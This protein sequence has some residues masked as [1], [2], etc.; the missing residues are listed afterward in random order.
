MVTFV[1]VFAHPD[2]DAYGIAGSVGLHAD[3]ADFSSRTRPSKRGII[4]QIQQQVLDLH[5]QRSPVATSGRSHEVD[6]SGLAAH[7][8]TDLPRRDRR[9]L[10]EPGLDVLHQPGRDEQPHRDEQDSQAPPKE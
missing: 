1:G 7:V 4:V 10:Q 6:R 2:D 9:V 3:D 8:R 5:D